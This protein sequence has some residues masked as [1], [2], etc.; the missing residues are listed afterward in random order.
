MLVFEIMSP[1][2]LDVFTDI[3]YCMLKVYTTCPHWI[4]IQPTAY[5]YGQT[6]NVTVNM[7]KMV[8]HWVL[9]SNCIAIFS[10]IT[11]FKFHTY[12]YDWIGEYHDFDP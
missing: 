9:E 3:R 6:V 10:P 8:F 4:A 1:R 12:A 2:T 7:N 5:S 11:V